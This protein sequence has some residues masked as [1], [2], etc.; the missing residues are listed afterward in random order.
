MS[1]LQYLSIPGSCFF[2]ALDKSACDIDAHTPVL[3]TRHTAVEAVMSKSLRY[4]VLSNTDACNE[5]LLR[6]GQVRCTVLLNFTPGTP[7]TSGGRQAGDA[8]AVD[9][10]VQHVGVRCVDP[11]RRGRILQQASQRGG[12]GEGLLRGAHAVMARR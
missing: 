2:A 1:A 3:T 6:I 4:L 11:C 8:G 12:G 5:D 7:H 9:A 10:V